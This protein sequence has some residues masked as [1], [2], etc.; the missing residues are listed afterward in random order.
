MTIEKLAPLTTPLGTLQYPWLRNPDTKFAGEGSAGK[1]KCAVL[2]QEEDAKELCK[3]LDDLVDQ[4]YKVA[5]DA[6]KPQN[7]ARVIKAEPYKYEYNEAGDRTGNIIFQAKS[8]FAPTVVDSQGGIL[9]ENVNP[10]G[11]STGSIVFTP[12]FY[13]M[14][15]SKSAGV[16]CYLN[17]VQITNLVTSSN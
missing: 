9:P 8:Q 17:Q 12:K 6:A 16:T 15:S 10:Y 14:E 13:F 4:S 3:I 11:G 7:K 2:V 5:F 1:Y